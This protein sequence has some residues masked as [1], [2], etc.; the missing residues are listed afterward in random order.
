[1]EFVRANPT[2]A[3]G[4]INSGGK[5]YDLAT[6][7]RKKANATYLES[8]Y[9]DQA[10]VL[11]FA[12]DLTPLIENPDLNIIDYVQTYINRFAK[13]VTERMARHIHV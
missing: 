9:I 11:E 5:H 1:M 7:G 3:E 12:M 10:K 13:D 6:Y 4:I 8:H 2:D